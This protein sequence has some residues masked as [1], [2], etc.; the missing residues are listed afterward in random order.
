MQSEAMPRPDDANRA[1]GV[2][3]D[4]AL[5][6]RFVSSR[7]PEVFAAL[8]ERHGPYLLGLCR[9]LTA[10]TQDA[11]DVFQACFLELVRSARS[12]SRRGSV[13]AW[14]HTVAVR[15]ARRAR[16]RREREQQRE[17]AVVKPASAEAAD[18]TWREVRQVLEEEVSR[19]PEDVR[20]PVLLCLFQERTQE[21]AACELRVN[22]RTLRD[23]LDR[24]RA[25]L[26][27]RLTRRG[28]TLAVLGAVLSARPGRA[29]VPAALQQ[30]T[31]HGATALANRASLAGVVSPAVLALAG[32]PALAGWGAALAVVGAV[33]FAASTA[34]L[35]AVEPGPGPAA[36]VA[37][38]GPA[39]LQAEDDPHTLR[40]SFRNK[41][42]DPRLFSWT[43]T[44]PEKFI[45]LEDEGLR[46][47]L[48]EK[49]RPPQPVGVKL[50]YAVCGDFDLEATFEILNLGR[51]TFL[52]AGVNVYL[53]VDSPERHG[54]W[55][56]KMTIADRGLH[57]C[58]GG[59]VSRG[60]ERTQTYERVRP[61]GPEA[62]VTRLRIERR[63]GRFSF[64]VAE[65]ADG[66]LELL[67]AVE[68]GAGELQV[69][70]LAAEP[71]RLRP[72]GV[73]ARLVEFAITAHQLRG[74]WETKR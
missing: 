62:G 46:I 4:G 55:L 32:S 8:L 42:F 66:P 9:R 36:K 11:E 17:A 60:Q 6:D 37:P 74:Q 49:D 70:R 38:A 61:T 73:D 67:D 22:P 57:F 65:G 1:P 47:T 16:A 64:Q 31:L 68:V 44:D 56:G 15:T 28:I 21:E 58:A 13:V 50:R 34:Y 48:A 23:R 33:L 39:R 20:A 27:A 14:L 12:I 25:R 19:L 72:T 54:L 30:A 40:R 63:G 69:V 24:G 35:V 43:G 10:Q 41:Q 26:R 7:D 51:P 52:S 18:I 2:P 71:G 5:L 3:T 59:N 29:A 53:L 45:R